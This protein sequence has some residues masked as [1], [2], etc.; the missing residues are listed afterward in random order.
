MVLAALG[1]TWT[2]SLGAPATPSLARADA[3]ADVQVLREGGCGGLMPAQRRLRHVGQLDRAAAEWAFGQPLGAAVKNSGYLAGK[4]AAVHVSGA[5]TAILQSMRRTR[6]ATF[7]NRDLTDAGIFRRDQ[8]AWLVFAA[9]EDCRLNRCSPWAPLGQTHTPERAG[10]AA[11][12]SANSARHA[13]VVSPN[14]PSPAFAA[15]V[16][17]LV[18]EVRARGTLCGV[19]AF[20]PVGPVRSSTAL[21]KVAYG[22]AVD[23]A[24]HDYFEHQDLAGRTPADR[25]RAAGYHEKLVGENIAY[26]P[27]SPD[28]VVRGWLDSPGHCENIMDSRFAETGITYA[29]GHTPGQG[30]SVGL[31]WVQV[32]ADPKI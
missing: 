27:K 2:L 4:L 22:H 9:A 26:G 32:L 30:S 12:T 10:L 29:V 31:Y 14:T 3:L 11:A 15:R 7:M 16:L 13:S 19:R 28:E 20:V 24:E 5:D 8:D 6:C 18:N 23:M 1:C 17:Q 25:V 21:E